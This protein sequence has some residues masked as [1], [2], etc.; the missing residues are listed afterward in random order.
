[1]FVFDLFSVHSGNLHGDEN[2]T[3]LFISIL[4]NKSIPAV[5]ISISRPSQLSCKLTNQQI[6]VHT[7]IRTGS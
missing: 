7:N 6:T 3:L 2:Y 4:A 1:M 5:M